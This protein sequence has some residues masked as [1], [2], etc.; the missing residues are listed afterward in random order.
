MVKYVMTTYTK[1]RYFTG[2][3]PYPMFGER[4]TDD[5]GVLTR[6]VLNAP[7]RKW[8]DAGHW[9][10]CTRE[11]VAMTPPVEVRLCR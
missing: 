1:G 8:G 9:V 6:L 3:K 5:M 10:R 11:G 7:D 2:F 4:V